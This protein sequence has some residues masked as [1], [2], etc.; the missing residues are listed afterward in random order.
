LVGLSLFTTS[1]FLSILRT[2]QLTSPDSSLQPFTL[3]PTWSQAFADFL[4]SSSIT[5]ATDDLP[6]SSL[7]GRGKGKGKEKGIYLIRGAKKSGKSTFARTVVNRLL[8]RFV[9]S[10]Q[11]CHSFWFLVFFFC[12][13]IFVTNRYKRVA[14]LECDLG[15]SEFTPGGTVAL[16]IV[17][18]PLLGM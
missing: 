9:G 1:F 13:S 4:P 10:F 5:T 7:N 12:S 11:S 17:E 6:S 15:Q 18:E 8:L 3:P 16:N 2:F 14:F